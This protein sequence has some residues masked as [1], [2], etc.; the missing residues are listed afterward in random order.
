MGAIKG[1]VLEPV[2]CPFCAFESKRLTS[3]EAHLGEKHQLTVESAWIKVNGQRVCRC[4][5]GQIP[6]WVGW[7]VGYSD[8]IIGHN[9]SI[10][11]YL[12]SGEAQ[13]VIEKRNST[14]KQSLETGAVTNWAKGL[15]KQT[16]D[17]LMQ[18]SQKRSLTV[19][20]QFKSGDRIIWSKGHT[21]Y[22]DDRLLELSNK[23]KEEFSSGSRVA[24]SVGLN[25]D[26]DVRIRNMAIKVS[27]S[28]KK[29]SLRKRLD[30]IKRL[31]VD[32]IKNRIEVG[33]NLKV[34]GGTEHYINDASPVIKVKCDVCGSEFHDSLRRLQ[35]GRCYICQPTGS[36]AQQ[37][38]ADYIVS[39]GVTLKRNDR[40]V[41]KGIELDVLVP[42]HNFAIEY[43][44]LYWHSDLHKSSAYHENKLKMASEVGIQLMHVFE[45]DWRDKS[46]IVKSMILHRLKM[47]PN[48]YGARQL[49][50][51]KLDVESRRKFF[52]ANHVDGDTAAIVAW[53][54]YFEKELVCALSIRKPFHKTHENYY[55][56]A[57]FCTKVN[58]HVR[59]GLRKLTK[60][61]IQ[62]VRAN[63]KA[64]LMTYVDRRI[65]SGIGYESSGFQKIGET[66]PRFWW[67]DF[68]NRFN[69]FKFKA[70]PNRG[71]TEAEVAAE[72]G[73]VKI[74]GCSNLIYRLIAAS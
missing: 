31:K 68:D 53:G 61:A 43:N 36:A 30:Q 1:R 69:R 70:D 62:F 51:G 49:R 73:V 9:A 15:S 3:F 74:W 5:C 10:Y 65:G 24:W 63:S 47:T 14:L 56:V 6:K 12:D 11:N 57:R 46:D 50:V 33:S 72:M 66:T 55:E 32:E 27:L 34:I 2:R 58:T 67:T 52:N 18:A 4:G 37:E 54:L 19:S 44:G 60:I 26:N 29:E 38:I 71:M 21:K 16:D 42:D 17:R 20:Q 35:R 59:G 40:S 48:K 7:K 28:L 13:Q 22:T 64:G 8:F 45:D 23:L 25:K 39:L 41:L